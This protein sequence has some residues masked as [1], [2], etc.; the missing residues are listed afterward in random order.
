MAPL[1][2]ARHECDLLLARQVAGGRLAAAYRVR[3]GVGVREGHHELA[4]AVARAFVA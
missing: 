1:A 4:H 2:Q 3:H